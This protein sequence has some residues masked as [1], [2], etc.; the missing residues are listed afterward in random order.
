MDD[1]ATYGSP[2]NGASPN[3]NPILAQPPLQGDSGAGDSEDIQMS[4]GLGLDATIKQDSTTPAP[5]N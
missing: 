3:S 2:G 5:G 1:S 4:E